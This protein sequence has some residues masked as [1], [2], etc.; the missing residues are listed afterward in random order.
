MIVFFVYSIGF[1]KLEWFSVAREEKK[2]IYIH[3]NSPG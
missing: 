1:A 3:A 2:T